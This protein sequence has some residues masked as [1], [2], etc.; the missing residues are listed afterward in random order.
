MTWCCGLSLLRSFFTLDTPY[1]PQIKC[2][3][4]WTTLSEVNVFRSRLE[5]THPRILCYLK[6]DLDRYQRVTLQ[7]SKRSVCK[8]GS[9]TKWK[10]KYLYL[11]ATGMYCYNIQPWNCFLLKSISFRLHIY[12]LTRLCATGVHWI[13]MLVYPSKEIFWVKKTSKKIVYA[14]EIMV[15]LGRQ[16]FK[17]V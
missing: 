4:P 11:K 2:L 3:F 13:D 6:A 8:I 14:E 10:S 15:Y 17:N 5:Q 16:N 12:F 7:V 1:D 9:V